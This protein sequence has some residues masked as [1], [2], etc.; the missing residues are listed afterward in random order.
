M[1]LSTQTYTGDGAETTFS[2]PF[3]FI[4][5]NHVKVFLDGVETTAFTWPTSSTIQF[6]TAPGAGVTILVDRDTPTDPSALTVFTD[7]SPTIPAAELNRVLKQA[8]FVAEE[9][10]DEVTDVLGKDAAALWDA[11]ST[12]ITNVDTPT[13][14][15]DAA[16]KQYVDA[17]SVAAG[18]VPTPDDPDDNNKVLQAD[19]GSFGWQAKSVTAAQVS[20]STSIGR[21][22]IKAANAAAVRAL[23]TPLTTNGDL[24]AR[25]G[26]VDARLALGAV[27]GMVL[28]RNASGELGYFHQGLELVELADLTNGGANDLSTFAFSFTFASGYTYVV[29]GRGASSSTATWLPRLQVQTAGGAW[30][31]GSSDYY[32]S[33]Q[34][35]SGSPSGTNNSARSDV[36]IYPATADPANLLDFDVIVKSA[37]A[38]GLQTTMRWDSLLYSGTA[39]ARAYGAGVVSTAED[40]DAL[41]LIL[42]DG[43]H[44]FDS[45]TVAI[46]RIKDPS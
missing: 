4:S 14:A 28:G 42:D 11:E 9:A 10:F 40:N 39:C 8:M 31:N 27:N 7:G 3:A 6:D 30:R 34:V 46:W 23:T 19:A 32:T 17:A 12:R 45:G 24:W 38:S 13:A 16:T 2:V 35:N 33:F 1:A 36:L 20:D 22:L 5:R 25:I 26:G 44:L 29:Q 15:A 37:R 18:N 41:R 43:S 21:D